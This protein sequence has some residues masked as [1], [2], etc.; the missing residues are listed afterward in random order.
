MLKNKLKSWWKIVFLFVCFLFLRL[1]VKRPDWIERY[2]ANGLYKAIAAVLRVALG[3]LPFSVGDVLI[4]L[5]IIYAIRKVVKIFKIIFRKQFTLVYLLNGLRKTV[6]ALLSAYIVFLLC[7][8]LNYYRLGIAYQMQLPRQ[9]YSTTALDSLTRELAVKAG[10]YRRRVAHRD[11]A[12]ANRQLFDGAL[13]SY[14]AAAAKFPFLHYAFRSVKPSLYSE[15]QNYMG[16]AGYLNPFTGEAQV[17]T[18]IPPL[19]RPFVTCHEMAHQ[20]GYGTE[21]EA[22]FVGYAVATSSGDDLYRY[23]AY[24]EMF[25]YA[26]DELFMRDSVL[27]RQAYKSLDTLVR[28]DFHDIRLFYKRYHNRVEPV[29]NF[30]YGQY[31]R[32]N[33]QPQGLD[34]YSEVVSLLMAYRRRF[35]TI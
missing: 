7:W 29:I 12:M 14:K 17:N 32:A 15:L 16:Y 23:S 9:T 13:L 26:N 33:N 6:F 5:L 30:I 27:A 35:G 18:H 34:T 28:K 25:S 19:S 24:M 31:L 22:N 21:D 4:A 8:G 10:Y 1:L 2:Y 11:F 3:W 20:L